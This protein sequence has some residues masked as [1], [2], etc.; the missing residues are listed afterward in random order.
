MDREKVRLLIEDAINNYLTNSSPTHHPEMPMPNDQPFINSNS[1]TL[2]S[3][4]STQ[5]PMHSTS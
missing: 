4:S 1:Q 2:T 5:V 3:I